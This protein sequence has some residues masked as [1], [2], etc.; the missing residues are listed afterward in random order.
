VL[1]AKLSTDYSKFD[2]N[3]NIQPSINSLI[4]KDIINNTKDTLVDNLN[5]RLNQKNMTQTDIELMEFANDLFDIMEDEPIVAFELMANYFDEQQFDLGS[6]LN[7]VFENDNEHP[8]AKGYA[9]LRIY[10]AYS[11]GW[12]YGNLIT[13]LV[14]TAIVIA[15]GQI[16]A[17]STSVAGIVGTVVGGIVGAIIGTLISD[18][19]D[20]LVNRQGQAGFS[21]DLINTK[22]IDSWL[23]PFKIN[24]QL[25]LMDIVFDLINFAGGSFF[26]GSRDVTKQVLRYS[27]D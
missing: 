27:Y 6:V 8:L 26:G 12:F 14:T 5:S 3:G 19:I 24:I 15:I 23:F 20:K 4:K 18:Q 17:L 9:K 11:P 21:I 1:I 25:N 2:K 10:I 16:I 7:Q 22:F 13:S